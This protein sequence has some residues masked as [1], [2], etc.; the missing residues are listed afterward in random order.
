MNASAPRISCCL[1]AIAAAAGMF[2]FTNQAVPQT[3]VSLGN[4]TVT[5]IEASYMPGV[6][7]FTLSTGDTLCP[8]GTNLHWIA[9]NVDN[10]QAVYATL[11]A[12]LLSGRQIYVYYVTTT[13][14]SGVP[15]GDCRVAHIGTY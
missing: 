4:G 1:Y 11:L 6:I 5:W 13:R 9:S 12:N 15:P 2:L 8:A 10:A 3:A 7:V 14:T